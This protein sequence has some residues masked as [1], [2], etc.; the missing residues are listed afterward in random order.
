MRSSDAD[1]QLKHADAPDE[2]A[3]SEALAAHVSRLERMV[4]LRMDRSRPRAFEP[5]DVVQDALLEAT[6][7]F[8]EWRA[9]VRYPLHV[10]LRLLT[11]QALINAERRARREKRDCGR[12][13]ELDEERPSVT[14]RAAADC[15]LSTH[16]SPTEAARRAE[17][18][19]RVAAAL[20]QIDAFDREIIAL[21]QFEQLS[22]EEAAAELG[23]S[24]S[25]ATKR[26]TRALQ[27]LR[28]ALRS[29]GLEDSESAP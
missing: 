21:R 24:P 25:A 4:S 20:E 26:F 18:R 28:P 17:L 23:I 12:E 10:W 15:L 14:P 13:R 5:A 16:T 27:R 7:R 29:L 22:N 2:G 1:E 3:L 8:D 11:A 19:E 9:Q 6:R